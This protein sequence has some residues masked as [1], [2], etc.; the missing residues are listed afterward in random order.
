M[1]LASIDTYTHAHIPKPTRA[2]TH[3]HTPARYLTTQAWQAPLT[4]AITAWRNGRGGARRRSE[5][6]ERSTLVPVMWREAEMW[7]R[8]WWGAGDPSSLRCHPR[9]RDVWAHTAA[10]VHCPTILGSVL[11]SM[12]HVTIKSHSDVCGLGHHQRQCGCLRATLP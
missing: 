12:P 5:E 10:E 2:R 9:P 11:M 8:W 6:G 4:G 3:T 7:M 1:S